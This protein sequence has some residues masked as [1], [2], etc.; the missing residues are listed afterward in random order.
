MIGVAVL[1]R[2]DPRLNLLK[3]GPTH[4]ALEDALR[5]SEPQVAV[6]DE[7]AEPTVVERLRS[8]RPQTRVLVLAHNPTHSQGMK[9]LA[10]GANCVAR[11]APDIDVCAMTHL[12]AQ[13]E[14]F[15]IAADGKRIERRYPPAAE[16][17]TDREQE[18]LKHLVR[19]ASYATIAY[20]LCISYR[21][22]Q[23][24]V[25][26]IIEKLGVQ[27][28]RELLGMPLPRKSATR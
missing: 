27:D 1:L 3:C 12:T 24:Y 14:R 6:L 26:S 21:T 11:I 23:T 7:S 16:Q 4:A 18:V 2:D 9:L 5:R 15:F 20:E 28:R 10:A 17:L 22:V 25:R 8:V 19:G 13:G